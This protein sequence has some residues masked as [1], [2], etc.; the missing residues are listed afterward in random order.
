MMEALPSLVSSRRLMRRR[1]S[2]Y[3]M[4]LAK[5]VIR[6][7]PFRHSRHLLA[8]H[9]STSTSTSTSPLNAST[10]HTS[11]LLDEILELFK[12]I[13]INTYVDCTLGAGGHAFH[14]ASAHPEVHTILGID[15]DPSAHEIAR[16]RLEPL[17][18]Q[19]RLDPDVTHRLLHLKPFTGNYS[20]IKMALNESRTEGGVDAILMDLGV[21]SMQLDQ[22]ERGFSFLRDGPIDMRMGP[23]VKLSAEEVVNTWS[24][25]QLGR[26]IREYGEEKAW[27]LVARRIV[28]ARERQAGLIHLLIM[29]KIRT[30]LDAA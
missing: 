13:D 28:E 3:K 5:S 21:S 2:I 18:E 26:I 27:R 8:A 7:L 29:L 10:P 15:I 23:S 22:A 14:I 16:Q 25:A 17:I 19:R 12:P 11:V 4:R 20:E 1:F 6:N 24:E 9:A 30:D